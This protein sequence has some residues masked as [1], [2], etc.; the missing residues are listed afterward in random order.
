MKRFA[1]L[2][3]FLAILSLT[4][5]LMGGMLAKVAEHPGLPREV[6]DLPS[7]FAGETT[8]MRRA[9]SLS[10][11]AEKAPAPVEEGRAAADKS[12]VADDYVEV[13]GGEIKIALKEYRLVPDKIRVRPG[14]LAITFVLRN[15]GRFAH[16]FHIEGPDVDAR[17]SKFGP[18]NTVRL[19]V[20]LKE[21][22]YKISCPLSNHDKRGMHGTLLVTSQPKEG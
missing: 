21:G 6:G 19:E 1:A 15:E 18:G 22:E 12:T 13:A 16:N 9:P 17:A 3:S 5:A 20:T 10:A 7:W 11:P 14:R 4:V 8:A 2:A